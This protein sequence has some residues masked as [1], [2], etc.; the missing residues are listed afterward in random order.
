MESDKMIKLE[1]A[2]NQLENKI[3]YITI[4]DG[5]ENL[6]MCQVL[7]TEVE[8][9]TTLLLEKSDEAENIDPK[10]F[11][12][13]SNKYIQFMDYSNLLDDFVEAFVKANRRKS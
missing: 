4:A 10:L 13:L 2:L 6:N 5:I 12:Y 7:L 1:T 11:T 3:L 8:K 9:T